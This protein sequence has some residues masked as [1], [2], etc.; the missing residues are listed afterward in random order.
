MIN[1][2]LDMVAIAIFTF[3]LGGGCL[4]LGW[5]RNAILWFII[6][7]VLFSSNMLYGGSIPFSTDASGNVLPTG[8][9]HI[10]IGINLIGLVLALFFSIEYAF[11]LFKG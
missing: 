5:K 4:Y 6:A 3:A 11:S 2:A 1:M 8:A 10:L 9:N 7:C